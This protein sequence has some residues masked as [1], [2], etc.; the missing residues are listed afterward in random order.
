MTVLGGTFSIVGEA[1]PGGP[2]C[3]RRIQRHAPQHTEVPE[4]ATFGL[5]TRTRDPSL[6][7]LNVA[8]GEQC[9]SGLASCVIGQYRH[10]PARIYRRVTIYAPPTF[11]HRWRP[12]IAMDADRGQASAT[13]HMVDSV[14]RIPP[15]AIGW[16]TPK[17]R[18]RRQS[19][20]S[21]CHSRSPGYALQVMIH[22]SMPL[23]IIQPIGISHLPIYTLSCSCVS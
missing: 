13:Q 16:S 20:S 21:T 8:S 6:P 4:P 7:E 17:P 12:H 14:V 11:R 2:L 1:V 9:S 19:G 23:P 18:R 15:R 5:G 3:L 10:V 22:D